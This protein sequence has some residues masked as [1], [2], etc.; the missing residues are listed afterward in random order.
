M[1]YFVNIFCNP[2]I[3][4]NNMSLQSIQTGVENDVFHTQLLN[5]YIFKGY[6]VKKHT[7]SIETRLGL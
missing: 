6:K 7:F 4:I 1:T 3:K 2:V 5:I